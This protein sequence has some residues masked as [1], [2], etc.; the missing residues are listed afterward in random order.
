MTEVKAR[1]ATVVRFGCGLVA[2]APRSAS[3][4][5]RKASVSAL[6]LAGNGGCPAP[7]Q[8]AGDI[9]LYAAGWRG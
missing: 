2:L 1:L 6:R 8:A 9:T 4:S 5:T 3:P 7:F